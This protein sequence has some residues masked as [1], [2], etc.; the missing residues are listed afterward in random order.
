MTDDDRTDLWQLWTETAGPGADLDVELRK[1]LI[2]N[3]TTDLHN[4]GAA[5]LGW[6]K[7]AA[8]RAGQSAPGCSE[9]LG[10]WAPDEFGQPSEHR[11]TKCRPH[12]RSVDAS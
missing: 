11:C 4:P 12:L 2:H 9:C 5:L 3:T 1:W 7:G 6:L 8:K 10:G